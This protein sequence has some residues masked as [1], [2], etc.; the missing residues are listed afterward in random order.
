M[1]KIFSFFNKVARYLV[2]GYKSNGKLYLKHLKD[3]GMCIG[4]GVV[5]FSAQT[6]MIDESVP[7]MVTI[8]KNVQIT[9]GVII[10][11]H[12]YGWSTL[13]AVYG[14]VLGST[15]PT[16]IGD[17]V[18]IGM[19]AI[20]LAG[21][22]IGNNVVIGANSVV[23]GNIPDNCVAVGSPCKPIYSLEEYH[24]KRKAAQLNEA[25]DIIRN[26]VDCY[27]KRPPK[28]KLYEHFW[29]F[30]KDDSHLPEHF[31]FQNNLMP[32]SEAMTWN[33]FKNHDTVFV[34]YDELVEYALKNKKQGMVEVE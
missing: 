17:N 26:Y 4:D 15:R 13:K 11:S 27:G 8:G 23:S 29:L 25:V 24:N 34:N 32:G 21:A 16:F 2:Y 31:V 3:K 1:S 33:N 20:I 22:H 19:N 18:Y 30:E 28:E 7:Y 12:D 5:L 10:L 9:G 14:D 6:T